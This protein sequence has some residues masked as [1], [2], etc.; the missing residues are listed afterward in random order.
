MPA[1]IENR[2]YHLKQGDM[3]ELIEFEGNYHL[4]FVQEKRQKT[5]VP[6]EDV[7]DTI[8]QMIL[9]S[10]QREA[11]EAFLVTLKDKHKMALFYENLK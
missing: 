1:S 9:Q 7:Q 5:T 2:L 11:L 3:S 10:K 8:Y 4:F 6:F